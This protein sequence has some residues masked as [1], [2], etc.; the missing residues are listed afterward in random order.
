MIT[1]LTKAQKLALGKL[2][3]EWQCAYEL[4]VQIPTLYGLVARKA[5]VMKRDSLGA[6]YSPRTSIYFK[7]ANP[8]PLTNKD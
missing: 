2:T 6:T 7:L 1:K 8:S 5:A 4:G 3:H